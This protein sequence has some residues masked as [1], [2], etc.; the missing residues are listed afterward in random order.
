VLRNGYL[1][2]DGEWICRGS[3]SVSGE[4]APRCGFEGLAEG[5]EDGEADACGADGGKSGAEYVIEVISDFLRQADGV[6]GNGDAAA[7][8]GLDE[9]EDV[10][11]LDEGEAIPE[12]GFGRS[13]R[14]GGGGLGLC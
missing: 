13:G 11:T 12:E 8:V 6:G 9:I 2:I 14:C 4:R 1:I 5:G 10:V 3:W 7:G